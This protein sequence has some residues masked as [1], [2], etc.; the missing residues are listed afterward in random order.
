MLNM[1][2]KLITFTAR[3][4][5]HAVL[6]Q[7]VYLSWHLKEDKRNNND[8]YPLQAIPQFVYRI[9][10]TTGLHYKDCRANQKEPGK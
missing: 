10:M 2:L 4:L 1:V 5:E 6:L 3:S 8:K 9:T 7:F